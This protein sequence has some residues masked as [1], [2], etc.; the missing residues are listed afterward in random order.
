MMIEEYQKGRVEGFN[1][2]CAEKVVNLGNEVLDLDL[3]KTATKLAAGFGLGMGVKHLC[4]AIAGAVMVLSAR[5]VDTVARESDIY[6]RTSAFLQEVE[7]TLG[8]WLCADLREKYYNPET[9]CE[10]IIET[11]ISCL[12]EHL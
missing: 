4:G 8:S 9:K 1:Y 10:K 7:N 11:V 3:P 2:N 6:Q 12:D 5:H